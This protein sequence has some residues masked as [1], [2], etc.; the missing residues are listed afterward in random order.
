MYHYCLSQVGFDS[1]FLRTELKSYRKE[2]IAFTYR[3]RDGSLC[4]FMK[5][6]L[7]SKPGGIPDRY[8]YF[9]ATVLILLPLTN[10]EAERMFSQLKIL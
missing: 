3:R 6:I 1:P 9:L 7:K 8:S 4:N 2:W 5:L 10:V